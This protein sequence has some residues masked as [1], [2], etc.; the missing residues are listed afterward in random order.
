MNLL[1]QRETL[2]PEATI[3]QLLIDGEFFCFT[4]EDRVRPTK[5]AGVTAIPEGRYKVGITQS[6]R[7]G[8][9]L[10]LL[11]DV[12]GFSGI[13]IHVG[14]VAANTDGCLLVGL[15][16]G[17]NSVGR[18]KAAMDALMPVLEAALQDGGEAWITIQNPIAA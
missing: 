1:L 11:Y 10:P 6:L 3:G 16:K 15:Q 12:P 9:P 13:R 8:K 7:F 14:N 4:L 17:V 18:S 5:I 2:T